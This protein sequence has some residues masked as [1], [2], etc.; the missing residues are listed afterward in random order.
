MYGRPAIEFF[1]VFLF[2][3]STARLTRYTYERDVFGAL[4][5]VIETSGSFTTTAPHRIK[6]TIDQILFSDPE[7]GELTDGS[8]GNEGNGSQS[9][10]EVLLL[11]LS[12]DYL[13][14]DFPAEDGS[15]GNAGDALALVRFD[16][17]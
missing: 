7:T 14:V 6:W 3:G 13:K 5:M 8:Q 12:G 10:S 9:I 2:D 15:Y 4:P 16:C 11:T 1:D 17:P